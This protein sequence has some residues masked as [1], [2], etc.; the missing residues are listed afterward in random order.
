[1]INSKARFS[2]STFKNVTGSSFGGSIV[3]SNA[4]VEIEDC[5]FFNNSAVVTSGGAIYFILNSH[6]TIRRLEFYNNSA[7]ERG[8][9]VDVGW[10]SVLNIRHNFQIY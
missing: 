2:N 3:G 7:Q 4:Q 1:M 6:L 9:A 8:R 10:S 5:L